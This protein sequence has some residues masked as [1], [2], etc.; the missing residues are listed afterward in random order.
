MIKI[1][2]LSDLRDINSYSCTYLITLKPINEISFIE[3]IKKF[4]ESLLIN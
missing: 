3:I 2:L 4:L 1:N